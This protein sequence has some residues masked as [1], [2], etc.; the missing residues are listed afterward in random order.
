MAG[1]ER[2]GQA[3]AESHEVR[4]QSSTRREL[5]ARVRSLVP[6]RLQIGDSIT[7]SKPAAA[8]LGVGGVMTGY[9]WG[10]VRGRRSRKKT[11]S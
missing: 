9:V 1:G 8:A 2:Y 6:D 3:T 4:E 11:K 5:E 10:W 7:S